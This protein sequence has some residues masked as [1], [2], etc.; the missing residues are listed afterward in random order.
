M[1]SDAFKAIAKTVGI[2][3]TNAQTI[4]DMPDAVD[5][6]E[7]SGATVRLCVKRVDKSKPPTRVLVVTQ[8]KPGAKQ[9]LAFVVKVREDFVAGI[10]TL[11][12]TDLLRRFLDRFGL[13]VT[14]GA[15][16]K[17]LFLA[18]SVTVPH[19]DPRRPFA[20]ERGHREQH[21]YTLFK[22]SSLP[23]GRG[24]AVSC[25]L[26]FAVEVANYRDYLQGKGT[27]LS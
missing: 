1:P 19:F 26:C 25:A 15:T 20:V 9:E 27:I 11:S 3:T 21:T 5:V 10:N 18:E 2:S 6:I 14:F 16:T 4:V 8:Q 24:V 23:D 12:P 17:K 7:Y 13:G 22:F